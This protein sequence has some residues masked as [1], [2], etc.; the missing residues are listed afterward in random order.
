M[1]WI[2]LPMLDLTKEKMC[3][4]MDKHVLRIIFFFHLSKYTF[5]VIS[6][7]F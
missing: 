6:Y 7:Q 3:N 4:C 2:F 5:M 1:N